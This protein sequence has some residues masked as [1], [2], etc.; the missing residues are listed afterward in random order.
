M[1][2]SL[3]KRFEA[4]VGRFWQRILWG[5]KKYAKHKVI[6]PPAHRSDNFLQFSKNHRKPWMEHFSKRI[7]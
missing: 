2:K 4:P 6:N 3:T 1:A 5:C 7:N